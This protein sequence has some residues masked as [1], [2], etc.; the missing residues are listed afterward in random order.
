[1]RSLL[2]CL[3]ALG[4]L[5]GCQ[6]IYKLPTRQGNVLDQ[7]DLDKLQLGMTREQVKFVLGT[8]VATSP[9]RPDQWDY[10]G[11]YKSP[12]GNV[13]TRTVILRFEGDRLASME[14]IQQ[15]PD[16]KGLSAPDMDT[17]IKQERKEKSESERGP[18]PGDSGVVLSPD[19]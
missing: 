12:R 19:T 7:K 9:F 2:L 18:E 5:S 15:T 3:L 8:P 13:S 4:L 14:G 6:L 10:F 1:M 17:V 16:D 11:Y